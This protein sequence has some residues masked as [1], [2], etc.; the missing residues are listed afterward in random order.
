MMKFFVKIAKAINYFCKKKAS[1]Q[2]L[3]RV[4]NTAVVLQTLFQPLVSLKY[5]NSFKVAF[6]V[7]I[8][9]KKYFE[10]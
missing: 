1:S 3:D 6:R 4:L 7:Q 8:W 5:F 9:K 2:M 10:N